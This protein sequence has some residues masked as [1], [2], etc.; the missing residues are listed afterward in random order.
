M[1]NYSLGTIFISSDTHKNVR[2]VLKTARLSYGPF[3]QDLETRFARL[4]HTKEAI[5]CSSGTAALHT[6]LTALK[7]KHGWRDGDEVLVPIVTFVATINAVLQSGLRPVFIDILESTYNLDPNLISDKITAKSKAILPVH[8]FGKPVDMLSIQQVANN[9]HL[10]IIEDA[11]E[12]IAA[13]S[14]GKSVGSWGV[15]AA[16]S[17]NSAHILTTGIGGV[18]TTSDHQ[19]AELMRS[20]INHGRDSAYISIDDDN[21]LSKPALEKLVQ[22]RFLF[23]HVGFS[24]RLSE[25]EAAVAVSQLNALDKIIKKRV[26]NVRYL[27]KKLK[28]LSDLLQLPQLDSTEDHVYLVYPL[29]LTR[30]AL[31]KCHIQLN[32]VINQLEKAGIE[33]RPFLPILGQPAYDSLNLN[34]TD[35]PIGNYCTQAGFYVGCH[36]DLTK[37]DMDYFVNQLTSALNRLGLQFAR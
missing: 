13:K 3:C 35:F 36:Q 7:I 11:C 12:T 27:N 2:K 34:P 30:K 5:V 28:H 22:K 23:N 17:T 29:L 4:H 9:Y 24:Y 33:T 37:K 15:A 26:A 6:I 31:K 19:L 10:E 16:F 25:L 18:I 8:L 20:L 1:S 14:Q 32:Q 21:N